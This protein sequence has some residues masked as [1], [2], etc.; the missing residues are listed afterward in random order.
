M[1]HVLEPLDYKICALK[2]SVVRP[3]FDIT[4][5]ASLEAFELEAPQ[6]PVFKI[7]AKKI[8]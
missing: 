8:I 1:T 5:D 4:K 3:Y 2:V 6:H 7:M